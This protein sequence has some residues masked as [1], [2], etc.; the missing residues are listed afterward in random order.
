MTNISREVFAKTGMNYI[1]AARQNAMIV[2]PALSL[3]AFALN[4][5][6]VVAVRF[7]RELIT[8]CAHPAGPHEENRHTKNIVI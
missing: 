4:T 6:F 8:E 2:I 3:S 7:M 5:A 1:A